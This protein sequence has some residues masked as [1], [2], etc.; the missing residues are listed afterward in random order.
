MLFRSRA[1]G[2]HRFVAELGWQRDLEL[3]LKSME[4]ELFLIFAQTTLPGAPI[5]SNPQCTRLKRRVL[6]SS[7]TC[8]GSERAVVVLPKYLCSLFAHFFLHL[9]AIKCI[10]HFSLILSGWNIKCV[11]LMERWILPF[12]FLGC[13]NLD[14]GVFANIS[15]SGNVAEN[16]LQYFARISDENH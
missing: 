14:R 1:N 2:M 10:M 15:Q 8:H 11:V 4:L 16:H 9:M 13:L 6:V 3:I 12:G 7:M 5:Y